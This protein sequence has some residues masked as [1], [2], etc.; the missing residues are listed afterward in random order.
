MDILLSMRECGLFSKAE[1]ARNKRQ[2]VARDATQSGVVACA[3]FC[4]P[5][6]PKGGDGIF[7]YNITAHTTNPNVRSRYVNRMHQR[8]LCAHHVDFGPAPAHGGC[9]GL[10]RAPL[11]ETQVVSVQYVIQRRLERIHVKLFSQG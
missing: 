9:N 2:R 4:A 10:P 5:N 3:L 6:I 8:V 11:L 1:K 7:G